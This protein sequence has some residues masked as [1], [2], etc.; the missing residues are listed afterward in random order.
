VDGTSALILNIPGANSYTFGNAAGTAVIRDFSGGVVSLTKSGTG[1]QT[2]T[3]PG[4]SYT[5]ATAINQG[6]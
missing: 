6:R 3:G 1:T 4:I 2:L 5:G